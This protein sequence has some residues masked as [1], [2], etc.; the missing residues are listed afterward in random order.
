VRTGR[1]RFALAL[2]SRVE[3]VEKASA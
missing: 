3:L 2:E 1:G